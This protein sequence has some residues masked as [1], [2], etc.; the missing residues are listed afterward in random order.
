M[1]WGDDIGLLNFG[2]SP[3]WKARPRFNASGIVRISEK[4]IE[5]SKPNLS[6]GCNASSAHV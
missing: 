4:R 3:S 5:A 2:P 6:I 1:S